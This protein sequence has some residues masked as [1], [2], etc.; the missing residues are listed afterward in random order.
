MTFS[1]N[2]TFFQPPSVCQCVDYIT[3]SPIFILF[4]T[5]KT[6]WL[7]FNMIFFTLLA[8]HKNEW[9][10]LMLEKLQ[11]EVRTDIGF[12]LNNI[13]NKKTHFICMLSTYETTTHAISDWLILMNIHIFLGSLMQI[14]KTL[15]LYIHLWFI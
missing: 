10:W 12:D 15:E 2:H 7:K 11:Q 9:Q 1:I 8:N 3:H 14:R 4:P 5:W 13:W 6:I